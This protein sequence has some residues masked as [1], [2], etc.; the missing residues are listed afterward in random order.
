MAFLTRSIRYGLW[1]LILIS[2]CLSLAFIQCT[3]DEAKQ[4]VFF[5][6]AWISARVSYKTHIE[7]SQFDLGS[8]PFLWPKDSS[9][10]YGEPFHGAS[11]VLFADHPMTAEDRIDLGTGFAAI[12]LP[13]ASATEAAWQVHSVSA[14]V[15]AVTKTFHASNTAA[16][17]AITTTITNATDTEVTFYPTEVICGDAAALQG[18]KPFFFSPSSSAFRV[19]AGPEERQNVE[20]LQVNSILSA[21]YE[22]KLGEIA[23][24]SPLD[25]LVLYEGAKG[26]GCDVEM[27]YNPETIEPVKL[28]R[29]LFLNGEGQ[30]ERQGRIIVKTKQADPFMRSMAVL[31]KV[32]LK[33][34]ESF[35][36]QTR[37]CASTS[38]GP[39]YAYEDG[40]QINTPLRAHTVQ[41]SIL[42]IGAYGIA[43]H[44]GIGFEFWD[45]EG[46]LLAKNLNMALQMSPFGGSGPLNNPLRPCVLSHQ[47]T[48]S[49]KEIL[50]QV[51]RITMVLTDGTERIVRQIAEITGP[52]SEYEGKVE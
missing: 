6:N 50:D 15:L 27:V 47:I 22:H 52:F 11:T 20:I 38:Y 13:V 37:C 24:H 25:W 45:K 35:T 3:H 4:E 44:G 51:Y 5:K 26:W 43:H 21:Q 2:P 17:L 7:L 48:F 33:P 30:M 40:I 49:S 46:K 8:H 19:L 9:R 32:T 29:M 28:N 12:A 34:G 10:S 36:F 41:N 16:I 23:W 18:Q 39:I 31:G 1:G 14:T 42:L